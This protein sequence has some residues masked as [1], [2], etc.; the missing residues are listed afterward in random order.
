M[1]IT[2]GIYDIFSYTI[3]GSL[4]LFLLLE[5]WRLIARTNFPLDIGNIG[6]LVIAGGLSF[7][8]GI[9]ISPISRVVW[10]PLLLKKQTMEERVLA[11]IMRKYAE[12]QLGFR[13]DQWPIIFAHIRREDLEL[14]NNID[15]SRAFNVMLRNVSLGISL[16]IITQVVSL[17]QDG[18]LLVH[19]IIIGASL[20]FLVTTTSQGLRFHEL[21]YLNI[22]E[23]AISTQLPLT[24]WVKLKTQATSTKVSRSTKSRAS[25][26]V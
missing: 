5:S 15:R 25:K 14:A 17:I 23:Y 8:L 3:P 12:V 4:Y 10:Y 9:I 11:K 18:N 16:F 20:V 19:V 22:F 13:A 26:Q 24:E 2:L 21:F 6:H 7:L 1:S